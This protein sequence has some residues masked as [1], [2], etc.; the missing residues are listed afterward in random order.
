VQRIPDMLERMQIAIEVAGYVGVDQANQGMVLDAF[1]KSVA[2]RN[3]RPMQQPV[4]QIRPDEKG[5]L[6]VLLSD[7]DGREALLG[8][9]PGIEIL[10]RVA[11]RRIFQAIMASHTAGVPLTF[12]AVHSRVEDADQRLLAVAVLSADGEGHEFTLEYG[13]QCLDSLRRSDYQ[14][15]VQELKGRIK[16]AERTGNLVEALR[17]AQELAKLERERAG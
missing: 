13:A 4:E 3:E 12:D 7:I 2:S 9:L 16:E 8:E 11:G 6:N 14:Q 1:K 10:Q 5:L 15:K 17:L